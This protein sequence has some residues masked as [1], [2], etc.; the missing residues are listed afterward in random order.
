MSGALIEARNH[1]TG[2]LKLLSSTVIIK[3][4]GPV[5]YIST[6]NTVT[7]AMTS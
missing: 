5:P 2:F 3:S 4:R 1:L 7:T 6:M